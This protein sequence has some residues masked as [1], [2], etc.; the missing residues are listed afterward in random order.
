MSSNLLSHQI[1]IH[2]VNF[3]NLPQKKSKK[4]KLNSLIKLVEIKIEIW[5]LINYLCYHS[6]LKKAENIKNIIWI[7]IKNQCHK[8]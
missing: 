2:S 6:C 3:L 8:H 7:K 4:Y 5:L 1:S